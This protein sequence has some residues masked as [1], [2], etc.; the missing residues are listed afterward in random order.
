MGE[1]A[2]EIAASTLRRSGVPQGEDLENHAAYLQSWLKEM[3]ND[4]AYIF[5]A[6]TQASKAAD[7]LLALAR[8][9]R[10]TVGAG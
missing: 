5:K 10:D 1:S 9:E 8:K 3:R 6:S 2:A 7:Y 4:P